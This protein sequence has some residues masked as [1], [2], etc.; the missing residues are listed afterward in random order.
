[1]PIFN[2]HKRGGTL[3]A[4]GLMSAYNRIGAVA[5]SANYG[6]MVQILRNEWDFNGCNATGFTGVSL[7]ASPKASIL[8]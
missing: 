4:L 1:M 5:S 2:W 6:V 3:D 7:K 8:L